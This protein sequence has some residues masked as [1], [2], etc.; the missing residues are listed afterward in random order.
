[1]KLIVLTVSVQLVVLAIL[2]SWTTI[3]LFGSVL[4]AISAGLL[5]L[6]GA[7]IMCLSKSKRRPVR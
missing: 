4:L 2:M 5:I 7:K 1:M 3:G 6:L